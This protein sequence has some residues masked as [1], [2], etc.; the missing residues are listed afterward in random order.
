[1]VEAKNRLGQM[2]V[3][4]VRRFIESGF[5]RV[6]RLGAD[7]LDFPVR[8]DWA[9][10]DFR[11]QLQAFGQGLGEEADIDLGEVMPGTGGQRRAERVD[12]LIQLERPEALRALGYQ[13]GNQSSRTLLVGQIRHRTRRYDQ[14]RSDLRQ[15]GPPDCYDQ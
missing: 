14:P 5:Q 13:G 1:M 15:I 9:N 6:E 8:E 10:Y 4:H 11:E 7:A 3:S 2:I 12:P